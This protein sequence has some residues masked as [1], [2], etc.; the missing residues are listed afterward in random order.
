MCIMLCASSRPGFLDSLPDQLL[1][2]QYQTAYKTAFDAGD[3]YGSANSAPMHLLGATIGATSA[4]YHFQK[5]DGSGN[6]I[7]PRLLT[8]SRPDAPA[9]GVL[10]QPWLVELAEELWAR[11]ISYAERFDQEM[12]QDMRTAL[13]VIPDRRVP[14]RR[15]Q[16]VGTRRLNDALRAVR[17]RAAV[18]LQV[19]ISE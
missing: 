12:L 10:R 15:E 16:P 18:E 6:G 17:E 19:L 13:H 14:D 5:P 2:E 8:K 4:K 7:L 1:P 9:Y 3:E 11:N